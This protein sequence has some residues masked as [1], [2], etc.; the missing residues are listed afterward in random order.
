MGPKTSASVI[1][2]SSLE[3]APGS[4]IVRRL[5]DGA[6]IPHDTYVLLSFGQQSQCK[7]SPDCRVDARNQVF[8]GTLVALTTP[9]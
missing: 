9:R 7:Q 2:K 1:E 6:S 3:I 8:P 5:A 4:P